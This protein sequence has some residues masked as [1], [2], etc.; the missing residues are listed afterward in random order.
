MSPSPDFLLAR[1]EYELPL[2]GLYD[3]PDPDA[4]APLVRPPAETP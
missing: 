3:T 2:I 1:L 4:F